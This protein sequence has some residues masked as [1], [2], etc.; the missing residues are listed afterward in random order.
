VLEYKHGV[1]ALVHAWCACIST[2][3]EHM[4]LH[5][6]KNTYIG[7]CTSCL[8]VYKS[9]VFGSS[10]L[11]RNSS[12]VAGCQIAS[13]VSLS[14]AYNKHIHISSGVCFLDT[15][16]FPCLSAMCIERTHLHSF[17][18]ILAS[19]A[20]EPG[21]SLEASYVFLIDLARRDSNN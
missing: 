18:K 7:S 12:Y 20:L 11:R 9:S 2:C 8:S 19:T 5:M 6:H 17:T 14:C 4:H 13:P 15:V 10:F 3:M 1:H 16:L 21:R